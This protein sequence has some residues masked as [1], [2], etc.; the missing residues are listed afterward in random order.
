MK[1]IYMILAVFA[2]LSMSLNAQT[3]YEKVTSTDQLVAGKK[4]IFV[5]ENGT[6]SLAMSGYSDGGDGTTTSVTIND[7]TITAGS[8]VMA[9]TL[10]ST[11]SYGTTYYTFTSSNGLLGLTRTGSYNNY[12]YYFTTGGNY[13]TWRINGTAS[14][15]YTYNNDYTSV[16]L[17]YNSNYGFLLGTSSNNQNAY[18]YV[19]ASTDPVITA[20]PT[21]VTLNSIPGEQADQTITVTG[22]NLT[23]DI[24]ATISGTDAGLFSVSPASLGTSGGTLTVTYSPTAVG[25]HTAT[26]TLSS[27]GADPVTIT[28]NGTCSNDVTVCDGTDSNG[29]LPIY[30]YY[31]DDYQVN[32]MIY[33]E[34]TS[35]IGKKL[36]SMTF[37]ATSNLSANLGTSVWTVKLGTTT[38]A[39]FASSLSD[40]TRLV[41]NDVTA[42]IEGYSITTGI[43]T[44]T[45]TFTTPFEYNGGNLLVDFQSTTDGGYATTS[46][47]GV[48]QNS[49]TG[50]NSYGS[51]STLGSNGHYSDGGDVCQ[52]L[53]KVTFTYEETGPKIQVSPETLT[54][55]DN[56]TNNTFSVQGSNLGTDDVGVTVPQGSQFSTTT[57]DQYWG[58]VNNN[59]SVSGTVTVTYNGRALSATETVTVANNQ[60]SATVTVTYE[61]DLYV[62]CDNGVSPWDFSNNPANAMTN[63]GN[64]IYTVSLQ[65]LPANSHILFGR[66]SGLTYYWEGD[67]NRLFIGAQ[68]DGGD[69]AYGN[70]DTGNLDTD[71][72]NDSPVKYHPIYLP[73]AGSYIITIDA[74]A[75]TFTISKLVLPPPENVVATPGDNMNATV[76]WDVPSNLPTAI[77]QYTETFEDTSVFPPFS[78]GGIDA[79]THTGAFGD[80]TLYD[81]T[82]GCTVYGSKQLNYDNESAP[83]A[84]FVFKPSE[85]TADEQYP[86]AVAHDAHRGAQYLE[87]ICPTESS[88]AAGLSDHWLISPELSGNAQTISFYI[89]EMVTAYGTETYE[90]WVSTT[91]NNPS[92]FTQLGNSYSVSTDTWAEQSVQLPADT[93]YFAIRHT[94]N[95]I[96]GLLID[97][98]TYEGANPVPI[99]PVSYNVYLDGVLVGNVDANDPLSYDFS[100]L[101]VGDHM[102]EI[103]AVYPGNI[104]SAKVPA[105]FTI[106]PP[107]AELTAPTDESIVNVGTNT[108]SGVSKTITI[109]GSYLTEGLTISVEGN[110][111]T[112]DPTTISADDVNNGTATVTVT[113]NGYNANAIGTLTITSDNGEVGPI[114]VHLT[115]SF[116]ATPIEPVTGLLRLHMLLCDQLKAD[117][118]DDN[119]HA[120]AY[121]YVLKYEPAGGETKQSNTVDVEIQKTECEVKGYYTKAE[122][123]G[124]TDG[125]LTMNVLTADVQFDLSDDND[126]IEFYDLQGKANGYPALGENYLTKLQ[127]TTNFTYV[128]MLESSEDYGHEYANGEHHYYD[129]STPILT[130]TYNDSFMS[131]APSLSTWGIQRR[132]FEDDGLDNTYGAPVWR[133][134]VGDVQIQGTPKLERQV[135]STSDNSPNPYTS[136][137]VDNTVYNLYFLG[138]NAQGYLPLTTGTY[139]T[140]IKYEPY[141]F[142]V[143]VASPTGKLRKFDRV[144]GEGGGYYTVD[145]GAVAANEKYC[146]G[147]YLID[148]GWHAEN[149]LFSKTIPGGSKAFDPNAWDDIMKFG[150]VDGIS[151]NDIKVYVRFYYMVEGWDANRDGEARPGNGAEASG[152]PDDPTTFIYEFVSNAE[153]VG[154][155][156]VNAQGM[157]SD[158]PFEGLNIVITRYS[159]GTTSTTK[160]IR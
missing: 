146:V 116:E 129:D 115:A 21:T 139:G 23:T 36:T 111:F 59:G 80:W 20:T 98:V 149:M 123:D 39:S 143:F 26:L 68:T 53:P 2:L 125:T 42:V 27:T 119:T 73:E 147:S 65:D 19:E 88:S 121:R 17:K 75:N 160:V 30:G 45:I 85:A 63:Q 145:A 134:R 1:K 90:I 46:F 5:Y 61:P 50:Y 99:Y 87:S 155:T 82:G 86:D 77:G 49:Y 13:T 96:F 106:T 33:P 117:I 11:T 76:T 14:G 141:M 38:Q 128:E 6:S 135:K 153:I 62:Y 28:L 35:L 54:I 66:A 156:Y 48:N 51:S 104:E 124:D 40:I 138:V 154:V 7:N 84:W 110:G 32:Q 114:T 132:Y 109:S 91:D 126:E 101:S 55:S 16:Y 43:N 150:A 79:S 9:F 58:F 112:V 97:D 122:I 92:S 120:D 95:N 60:T 148:D 71:P 10:G 25:T 47:Y 130:G 136:W 74:N 127:R 69:W 151:K 8:E 12:K 100:N 105:T 18:I 56:G 152:D 137:T 89:S 140:N 113:Y 15:Y 133:A 93:K 157:T 118:P 103:S 22:R 29:Y 102:V 81:A 3:L 94:S 24:T 72:T 67:D 41:P 4:V 31:N 131:Y 78:T 158:K 34:I 64:G 37:Y 144:M 107:P 44:M 52:F 159:D 108:G 57:D 83:H 142:R 70:N